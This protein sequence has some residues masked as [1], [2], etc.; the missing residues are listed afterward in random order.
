MFDRDLTFIPKKAI[1]APFYKERGPSLIIIISI[2]LAIVSA[3]VAGGFYFYKNKIN[4]E[5]EELKKSVD[6]AQLT[7][8]EETMNNLE[9][10]A[11]K[12][13]NAKKIIYNHKSLVPLFKLLESTTLESIRFS[14]F[15]YSE[16][17]EN[18]SIKMEGEAN[19]YSSLA[20]QSDSYAKNKDIRNFVFS[21]LSLTDKGNVKFSVDI[22]VNPS[23]IL[24]SNKINNK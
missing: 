16:S 2:V 10:M 13:K 18:V 15:S 19:S 17:G 14:N 1:S 20:N 9:D 7:V 24:Y 23:L 21:N 12:I 5:V 4:K 6:R 3:L 22:Q 8:D 11:E